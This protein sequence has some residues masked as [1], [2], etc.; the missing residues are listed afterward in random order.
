MK[1]DVTLIIRVVLQNF[2]HARYTPGFS[3]RV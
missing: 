1:T 2:F 3:L